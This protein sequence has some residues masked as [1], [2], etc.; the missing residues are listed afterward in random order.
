MTIFATP[1]LFGL[2]AEVWAARRGSAA[3]KFLK[4]Q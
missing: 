3:L 1:E 4:Q 2:I